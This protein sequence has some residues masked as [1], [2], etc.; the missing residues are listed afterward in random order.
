M[1]FPS[2][3]SKIA[4]PLGF[5]SD[6]HAVLGTLDV[7]HQDRIMTVWEKIILICSK[8]SEI[9]SCAYYFNIFC[10][11]FFPSPKYLPNISVSSV[12]SP[13]IADLMRAAGLLH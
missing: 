8:R 12:P 13:P 4:V 6:A 9:K 7:L 1:I 3:L 2:R 11:Y 10:F 5:F